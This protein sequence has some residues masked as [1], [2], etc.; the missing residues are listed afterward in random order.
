MHGKLDILYPLRRAASIFPD[1]RV[2]GPDG[3]ITY[4]EMVRRVAGWANWLHSIGIGEGDIFAVAD[5]NSVRFM[6]LVYAAGLTRSIILPVN[7][8]IPPVQLNEIFEEAKPKLLLYSQPFRDLTR[9]W[10]RS[11]ELP[12]SIKPIEVDPE[13]IVGEPDHDYVLL[14][15]SGTTGRPKG[16]LYN[17]WKMLEGGLSIAYQLSLYETNA[18]LSSRD[19]MLSLIPMFHIL[20][21]GSV[22][23]APYI[24]AKL[25]FVAKF[26]P[27]YIIKVME[28]EGVTWFNAVPTMLAMLLQTGARFQNVKALVGGSPLP[29][30]L[31]DNAREA[32]ISIS[33]IYGATDML[34]T[35]ISIETDHSKGEDLR[36]ILHPVP[37]ATI[38]VVKP[39]GTIASPGEMGEILFRSPWM[40]NGYYKNPE[41]TREAFRD[42]WFYTGDVGTITVDGG[43]KILDRLKDTVK[44]GGEW[45]PTSILESIISEVDG[46][47][48]VAVIP[49]PDE[50]W[51][52]RP[53]AI[54]VG[55]ASIEAIRDH[56]VRAVDEGRIAKWWIPDYFVRVEEL[57]MTSTGKINKRV[58]RDKWEELIG[59]QK[60]R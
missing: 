30:K 14:Y 39:D 57:P 9:L 47:A 7:F 52:E 29:K 20:S 58:L 3:A 19:V 1:R 44:S 24:G 43:L 38:R 6:E 25:V 34:A 28:E 15:T 23:I 59:K 45:I 5:V 51:G 4:R 32:G 27:H 42:G 21:W 60:H 16:V 12:P 11:M 2:V 54:F 50:K 46:V 55:S 8:R 26:D 53:A 22:F 56:L 10:S 33:M 37:G 31:W 48:M 17:Q 36:L 41:K 35:A 49:V 40:P 18:K 13:N